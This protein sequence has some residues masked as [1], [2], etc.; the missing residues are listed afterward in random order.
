MAA[1]EFISFQANE[2]V[3]K[4]AENIVQSKFY[5]VMFDSTT[6]ST[7]TEQEAVFVLYFDPSP[8]EAMLS[9]DFEPNGQSKDRV[10]FS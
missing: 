6:D 5:S 10:S 8:G 3:T 4:L 2:V 7:V 9:G 1:A